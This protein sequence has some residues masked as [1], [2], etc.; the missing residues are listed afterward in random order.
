MQKSQYYYGEGVQSRRPYAHRAPEYLKEL[1]K[2]ATKT[3]FDFAAAWHEAAGIVESYR[4]TPL[5]AYSRKHASLHKSPAGLHQ[6]SEKPNV[7]KLEA[8]QISMLFGLKKKVSI[9]HNGQIRT[10]IQKAEYLYHVDDFEVQAGHKEVI[11]SYDLEDLDKVWLFKQRGDLLVYLCQAGQFRK[12]QPYGPGKETANIV[13]A[14]LRLKGIEKRK[15]EELKKATAAAGEVEL[16]M[17]RFTEKTAAEEAETARLLLPEKE[18]NEY[19]KA[20]GAD[21]T[22]SLDIEDYIINQL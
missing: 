20:A 1:R 6:E 18:Q 13:A 14:S 2:E 3:G 19:K 12:P 7:T 9:K 10:E 21:L 16:M 17:G 22:G 5:S 8:Y 15:A 4:S 11:M